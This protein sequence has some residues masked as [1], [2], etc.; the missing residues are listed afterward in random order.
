[1]SLINPYEL[2]GF[3]SKNPN[4]EMKELKSQ[5]YTLSLICHPDKGGDE[6]QMKMLM[7]SYKYVLGQI[8][9]QEH[10]RTMEEEEEVVPLL[11]VFR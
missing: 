8:E 6:E 4:I 10:G 1:M 2:L 7:I 11:E 9:Y 5:Y 3:D